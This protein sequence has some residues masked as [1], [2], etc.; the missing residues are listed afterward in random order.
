MQGLRDFCDF[1]WRENRLG[2][3]ERAKEI[4]KKMLTIFHLLNMQLITP[5]DDRFY[6]LSINFCDPLLRI[7]RGDFK[8][9]LKKHLQNQQLKQH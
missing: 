7:E 2:L 6:T 1:V 5:S 9:R 4:F 3:K 8:W